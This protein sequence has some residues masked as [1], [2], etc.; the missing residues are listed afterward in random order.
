MAISDADY[1]IWLAADNQSRIV[2]VEVKAWSGGAEV[3]RYMSNYPFVSGPSDSPANQAYDDFV[4][5]VPQFSHR[6]SEQFTGQ[7]T[8]SW[9]DIEIANENGDRD[10]WLTADAWDARSVKMYLGDKSWARADF[11]KILDGTIADIYATGQRTLALKVRDKQWMLNVPAQTSLIGGSTAN[12][13]LPKPLCYGQAFNTEPVLTVAA[14]HEYQDHDGAVNAISTV[15]D[16]G[17]SVGFTPTIASGTFVLS[18]APAGRITAD[19]Q[20]AKPGGTY[21]TKC[22]DIMQHLITTHSALTTGDL[23]ASSFSAFNTTAPQALGLYVRERQNLI[24]LLDALI[25][26]VGGWYGFSRDG[27]LQLGRLEDPASG[28]SVLDLTADDLV[29]GSLRCIRRIVPVTTVRLGYRKNWTLQTDGVAGA[30]TEARR[31]D[32]AA[33]YLVS[34]ALDAAIKTAHPLALEPELAGTLMTVQS[35]CDTEAARRLA[36]WGVTRY[37]YAFDCFSAPARVS[38]G[39]VIKLTHPRFG[40]AGGAKA[41]VV[42][43]TE[44]PTKNRLSLEIWK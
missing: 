18:A 22:A 13:D 14:T 11:R 43:I 29:E 28:T 33:E 19:V 6:M 30:A 20:G 3:T 24:E 39:Q 8:P 36:L 1:A 32:L 12:K 27:L 38:L 40:F 35:D 31:A 37:V 26:S 10:S 7:S 42:G 9:G 34:K 41:V 25:Q 44:Q 2:L 16:N 4:L 5:S 17:V 21:L 23:D 15:Y